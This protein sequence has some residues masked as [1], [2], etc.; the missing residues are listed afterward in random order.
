MPVIETDMVIALLNRND[1]R[2]SVAENLF[3]KISEGPGIFLAGSALIEMELIYKSE[4][5]EK[6]LKRDIAHLIAI[7][8]LKVLPVTHEII[9]LAI[10]LR[11]RYSL[12]FFDS[13]HVATALMHD[14]KLIGTDQEYGIVS[15]LSLIAH[16]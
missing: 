15:G 3:T 12:S 11:E 6:G 2:H 16:S 1:A 4:R 8:N 13:H 7:P 10:E 5:I 9:L 14:G